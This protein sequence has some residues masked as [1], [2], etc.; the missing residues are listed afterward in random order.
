MKNILIAGDLHIDQSSLEECSLILNE[1]KELIKKYKVDTYIDT[2]DTFDFLTPNSDELDLFSNFLKDININSII[3]A[4]NSHESTTPE[5]S[6]INHFGILNNKVKVV[7]EFTDKKIYI[8]HFGL[9]ESKLQK[10]GATKS[11]KDFSKYEK[12]ILGHFHSYEEVSKNCVQL[13]CYDKETEVLTDQGWKYF[14][15]LDKTEKIATLNPNTKEIEYQK[16][17]RYI[18]YKYNGKMYSVHTNYLDICVTPN[19][20]IYCAKKEYKYYKLHKASEIYKINEKHLPR[21]HESIKQISPDYFILPEYRNIYYSGRGYKKTEYYQKEKKIPFDLFVEFMAWYLSEGNFGKNTV[22]ITQKKYYNEVN[23]VVCK[24]C[25]YLGCNNSISIDKRTNTPKFNIFSTQLKNY[26]QQFGKSRNKYIP[27]I[28]KNSNIIH[29]NLFLETYIKG[30]GN[31]SKSHK[32]ISSLSKKMRND[33]QELFFKLGMSSRIFKKTIYFHKRNFSIIK[34]IHETLEKYKGIV[35][36]VEVP[37]HII[38]VRR[39]GIAYWC[40]NSSRYVTFSESNDKSKYV[41][42]IQDYNTENEK[43]NKIALKSPYPMI[44]VVIDPNLENKARSAPNL[45]VLRGILDSFKDKIKV[46]C[47]FKDYSLWRGFLPLESHYKEKFNLFKIKKD[48]ATNEVIIA[49]KEKQPLKESLIK[50][51]KINKI[52][53]KIRETLLKEIK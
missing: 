52:D 11:L 23:I 20:N 48:F 47:I 29:L 22:H 10:Y 49:K 5:S 2:G 3:L 44:D 28:I 50:W 9:V 12:V 41:Y 7:K 32:M 19:H 39:N 46:R 8:G 6:I 30:D 21:T 35:Y 16:P 18:E 1:Q 13:G 34:P 24:L 40:G 27:L 38:Y 17:I 15:D 42:I 25:K 14:K 33:F 31:I 4:A 53:N 37:N 43:V 51:M 45:M 26:L 36:C